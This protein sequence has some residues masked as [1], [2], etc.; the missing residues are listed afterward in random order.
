MIN[1]LRGP[2]AT[3][4][5]V[6]GEIVLEAMLYDRMRQICPTI[7]DVCVTKD[8][9]NLPVVVSIKPTFIGQARD[10]MLAAFSTEGR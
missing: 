8:G 1:D 4:N 7:R 9:V 10:V 5:H 2:P 3:D 6:M